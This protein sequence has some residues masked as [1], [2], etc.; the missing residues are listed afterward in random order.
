MWYLHSKQKKKPQ[1]LPSVITLTLSKATIFLFSRK[2]FAEFN[3]LALA[4]FETLPSAGRVAL[5]KVSNFA[6]CRT[7]GTRQSPH[8]PVPFARPVH[9]VRPSRSCCSPVGP[10][11][12]NFF[13]RVPEKRHS[14]KPASPED[15]R[16]CA[17]HH[18]LH[19]AKYLPSVF[20][21]LP[22]VSSSRQSRR[23][24]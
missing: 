3:Y 6:E 1:A 4:K 14:A 18:E 2:G 24:R 5:G 21:L 13:C 19:S 16:L 9:P 23:V 20:L 7:S 8:P 12:F 15:E 22:S 11:R 10:S 17:L